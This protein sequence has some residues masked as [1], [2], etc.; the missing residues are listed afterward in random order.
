MA[1]LYMA[2]YEA[3]MA[4]YEAFMTVPLTAPKGFYERQ[5]HTKPIKRRR[6]APVDRWEEAKPYPHGAPVSVRK[7]ASLPGWRNGSTYS[8]WCTIS[9]SCTQQCAVT[10][11]RC[12]LS[13]A[14]WT[15]SVA[16]CILSDARC[17]VSVAVARCKRVQP[18]HLLLER[19]Q[20]RL[21]LAVLRN[22]LSQW[23]SL[24]QLVSGTTTA[25]GAPRRARHHTARGTPRR[26]CGWHAGD[27]AGD[28]GVWRK[29]CSPFTGAK[30]TDGY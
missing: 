25:R 10:R 29:A 19:V 28:H 1:H 13:V 21:R 5:R 17:T 4:I 30:G 15:L 24:P 3:F 18:T 16:R 22:T 9:R 23:P 14:C 12:L 7:R 6:R 20:L 8:G 26:V 2:I 27:H 11:A